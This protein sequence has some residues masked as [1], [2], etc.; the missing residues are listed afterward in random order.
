MIEGGI[1]GG[2]TPTTYHAI[3]AV[4][5]LLVVVLFIWFGMT[6]SW[7]FGKVGAA[8]T[9]W[10]SV[11]KDGISDAQKG[12]TEAKL[13]SWPVS[14]TVKAVAASTFVAKKFPQIY[15]RSDASGFTKERLVETRSLAPQWV[16]SEWSISDRGDN[17]RSAI[18]GSSTIDAGQPVTISGFANAQQ[19]MAKKAGV[20]NALLAAY[21]NN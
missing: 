7:T 5:T 9:A 10:L 21:N 6:T 15:E 16:P 4:L 20:D 14:A 8:K 3:I 11:D 13:T 2:A 1:F 19:A 17:D 12:F 18:Q